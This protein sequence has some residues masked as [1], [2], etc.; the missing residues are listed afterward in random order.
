MDI[1]K[2]SRA[3]S[4]Q[5][6]LVCLSAALFFSYELMQL[7]MLNAISPMLMKDLSINATSFGY[8][9]STYLL[10]DVI[11]LLPAGMILDKFSAR[12]VILLAL[13]I[14]ILGCFGF[15]QAK[16]LSFAAISH[17]LSGIGNAFCFLSCMTLV[18]RWFPPKKQAFVIG[19]VITIGMLGGVLAQSPFSYLAMRFSWR[20]A[21]LID[22]AIGCAVLCIIFFCVKDHPQNRPKR[23]PSNTLSSDFFKDLKEAVLNKTN[24][25][26]GLYTGLMNL[27]IMVI[28]A[29]YGSLFLSQVHH[30]SLTH[31]SLIS[32]MIC[33]GT[34][35]GSSLFG[36]LSDK[37]EKRKSLML[38]GAISSFIMILLIML[39]EKPNFSVMFFLFFML[40]LLSSTQVLAYPII[41]KQ[42][43]K[44]LIGTSM[45]VAAVIIMG[46]AALA[47]PLVGKL[48]DLHWDHTIV[49]GQPVYL[50]SNYLVAFS[51]F[52]VS[53][54][55][56]LITAYFLQESKKAQVIH[57]KI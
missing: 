28:G 46:S 21:M 35:V 47:Q 32:G 33:M 31:S 17:F 55:I 41:T 39:L 22:A 7:H 26:C 16:T 37:M 24:I 29:V 18:S 49:N 8:L 50:L 51:I 53:F 14:C 5:A 45:G 42:S 27:P 44:H 54:I 2:P 48:M 6:W 25:L 34:I 23:S 4:F 10:A 11:F 52:P 3:S 12:K 30:F 19:I 15:A 36:Y 57:L 43:P 56:S 40:G 1:T 9:C 20:G 13:F 38:F